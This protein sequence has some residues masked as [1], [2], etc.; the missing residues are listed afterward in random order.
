[1]CQICSQFFN[2][3]KINSYRV[4][5]LQEGITRLQKSRDLVR[6]IRDKCGFNFRQDEQDIPDF[7]KR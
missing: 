6:K 5:L 3:I 7:L 4:G 2:S 1:M